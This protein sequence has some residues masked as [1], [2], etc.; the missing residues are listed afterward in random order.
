MNFLVSKLQAF[1]GY[2]QLKTKKTLEI[3]FWKFFP[4]ADHPSTSNLT[5]NKAPAF[6]QIARH[7]SAYIIIK[8]DKS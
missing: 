2:Q 8:Y 7:N 5:S 4:T 1:L 3:R 6:R